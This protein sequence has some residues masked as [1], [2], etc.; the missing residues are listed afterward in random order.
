MIQL[1]LLTEE[2]FSQV[3]RL[4]VSEPSMVGSNENTLSYAWLYKEEEEVYAICE[5]DTPVGL[6]MVE[7]DAE[8][9]NTA[10]LWRFMI[11]AAYQ[12][13]GYGTQAMLQ[14]LEMLKGRE[15]IEYVT[16]HIVPGNERAGHLYEKLG[17]HKTGKIEDEEIEM[18]YSFERPRDF[19][20][21]RPVRLADAAALEELCRVSMG[22][23]YP[24]E[25]RL[26]RILHRKENQLLAACEKGIVVGYIHLQDY[27]V[28]YAGPMKNILGLAVLPQYRRRGWGRALL[29]AAQKRAVKDGCTGLRLVSGAQRTEAHEFY[30]R[31]GFAYQKDQKNFQKAL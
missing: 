23:D 26:A 19:T 9:S 7:I 21:V 25:K 12:G 27:D 5:G 20:G 18:L 28:I 30:R 24:V 14:L 6:M 15:E 22:Y 13:R 11:D 10:F 29:A 8:E 16:L 1:Q 3:L 31:C 2:L 4:K 17:F